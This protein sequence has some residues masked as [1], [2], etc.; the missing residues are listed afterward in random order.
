MEVEAGGASGGGGDY[1]NPL[2]LLHPDPIDTCESNKRLLGG[3]VA[4]VVG[5]VGG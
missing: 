2:W 4:V 5:V 3:G 1:L